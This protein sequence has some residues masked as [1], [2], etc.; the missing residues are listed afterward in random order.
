MYLCQPQ[1]LQGPTTPRRRFHAPATQPRLVPPRAIG[2]YPTMPTTRCKIARRLA[3]GPANNGRALDNWAETK[4]VDEQAG[5]RDRPT[6]PSFEA[7]AT[8]AAHRLIY[9]CGTRLN[10]DNASMH[11]QLATFYHL[12][13][14]R[15]ERS[16]IPTK[17]QP[18]RESRGPRISPPGTCCCGVTSPARPTATARVPE[19]APYHFFLLRMA[20]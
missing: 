10:S 1:T 8:P 3:L 5:V 20:V 17:V 11:D 12:P 18:S 9:E 2:M 6:A 16:S 13:D 4:E 19:P 15:S 7:R 14:S